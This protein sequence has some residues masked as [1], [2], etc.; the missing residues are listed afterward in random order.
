MCMLQRHATRAPKRFW[1][2]IRSAICDYPPLAATAPPGASPMAT[3]I[4]HD[5]PDGRGATA[6]LRAAAKTAVNLSGRPRRGL[7]QGRAHID[8]AQYITGTDNHGARY[9]SEVR[10]S[11]IDNWS[12]GNRA[13]EKLRTYTYSNLGLRPPVSGGR[14]G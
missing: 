1:G 14:L 13:K 8:I 7:V 11:A 6:A 2:P 9:T 10:F 4:V 3:G 12:T 5:L